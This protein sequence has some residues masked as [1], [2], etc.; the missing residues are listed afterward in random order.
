[1]ANAVTTRLFIQDFFGGGGE[2]DA[3]RATLPLGAWRYTPPGKFTCSEIASGASKMQTSSSKFFGGGGGWGRN[4]SSQ[5]PC[6]K[7]SYHFMIQYPPYILLQWTA[8]FHSMYACVCVNQWSS[9][10]G[11]QG[12]NTASG[13]PPPLYICTG[14]H[15]TRDVK[16]QGK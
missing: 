5:P 7:S 11:R 14:E 6:H 16:S 8:I 4:P 12:C 13:Q 3:C 2:N 1:M 9:S 15:R 10:A